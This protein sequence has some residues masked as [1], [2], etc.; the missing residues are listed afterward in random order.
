MKWMGAI[1]VIVGCGGCGFA[2]AVQHLNRIRILKNFLAV[3]DHMECELQYRATAL[4]QLCRQAGE[5]SS[6]ILRQ[7][8]VSLADEL[9]AQIAPNAYLCM[10][11]VLERQHSIDASFRNVLME[12]SRNLGAFDIQ[13]QLKGLANTRSQCR[14]SLAALMDNKDSRLRSYQTLG[15]CVGAAVAILLV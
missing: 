10:A 15:L 1:C 9:D 13:G 14:E 8:F 2:M 5:Q 3:L 12:F 11:S 4:P 7:I 6:G